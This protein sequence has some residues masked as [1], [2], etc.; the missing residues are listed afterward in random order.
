[1]TFVI[2][3]NTGLTIQFRTD[4]EDSDVAVY[5]AKKMGWRAVAARPLRGD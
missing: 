4:T 2:T 5:R 3:L 1:M